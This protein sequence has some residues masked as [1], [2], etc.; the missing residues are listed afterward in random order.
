MTV[1]RLSE[2]KGHV[3]VLDHVLDL[4][5]HCRRKLS[6]VA[7]FD[8]S[9][10]G[11]TGGRIRH[12]GQDKEDNP[13]H[14]QNGPEDGDIEEGE[15]R[16]QESDGDGPGSRV[17]ELELRQAA[18]EGPELLILLRGKAGRGVAI[19][20][21]LVMREGGIELGLEEQEEQVEKID[22]ERVRHCLFSR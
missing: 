8:R 12:T 3:A 18:N 11:W 2:R 1:P 14:D 13:V 6:L 21:A 4:A 17:P 20:E 16:A 5:A 9:L 15:P 22:A 10:P 7:V 19:F